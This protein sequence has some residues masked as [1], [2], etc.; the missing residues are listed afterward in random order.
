MVQSKKTSQFTVEE[1]RNRMAAYPEDVFGVS[2]TGAVKDATGLLKLNG[3]W[4]F[5][6]V[7]RAGVGVTEGNMLLFCGAVKSPGP[8]P[9]DA[10]LNATD[11][12]VWKPEGPVIIYCFA[13]RGF[14]WWTLEPTLNVFKSSTWRKRLRSVVDTES[15]WL[16]IKACK[17]IRRP[18]WTTWRNREFKDG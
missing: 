4:L 18:R 10:G 5:W 14:R 2:I 11:G 3:D 9:N 8:G 7:L 13:K 6:E 17:G 1:T 12:W 15:I 16:L